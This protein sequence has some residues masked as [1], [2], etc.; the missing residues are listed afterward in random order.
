MI[1][2]EKKEVLK[3]KT[4]QLIKAMPFIPLDLADG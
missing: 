1:I 4:G 2:E 3:W